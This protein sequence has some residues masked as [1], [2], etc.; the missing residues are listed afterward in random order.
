MLTS[1]DHVPPPP[2][3]NER[4]FYP[5]ALAFTSHWEGG[6]IDYPHDPGGATNYGI[7]QSTYDRWQD[8]QTGDRSQRK[9]VSEITRDEVEEIYHAY[10]WKPSKSDKMPWP[11]CLVNFDTSVNFG[12]RGS[13]QFLQE[14]L[15]VTQDGI[16]G[17]QTNAAYKVANPICLASLIIFAR[18]R[19]RYERITQNATQL[20]FL[21]GWIARDTALLNLVNDH[22]V[23]LELA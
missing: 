3:K 13:V 22:V 16:L 4:S 17:P 9:P 10:Y 15:S 19:Y 8:D 7:T 2:P 1:Y 18:R 23:R 20:S 5:Y 21:D 14:A 11:L 12:V 6:Y